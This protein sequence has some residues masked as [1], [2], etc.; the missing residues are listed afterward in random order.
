[1][2]NKRIELKFL[3][4]LIGLV[5]MER[6]SRL[7]EKIWLIRPL[8]SFTKVNLFEQFFVENY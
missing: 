6:S 3:L 8:L 2:V 5:G 1:M 7:N 4:K